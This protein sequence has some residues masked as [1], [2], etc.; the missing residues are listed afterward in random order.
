MEIKFQESEK[1]RRY[2]RGLRFGKVFVWC[3]NSRKKKETFEIKMGDI[4]GDNGQN[5]SG[6]NIIDCIFATDHKGRQAEILG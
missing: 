5:F 6:C 4:G 3:G 1:N 2:F